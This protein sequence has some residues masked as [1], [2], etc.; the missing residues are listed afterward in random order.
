[1]NVRQAL[2]NDPRNHISL[3]EYLEICE[4]NGFRKHK[5]KLQL[6]TYL[7]ELGIC[8]HYQ[9][10]PLLNKTV[11]LKTDWCTNAVYKVL[12]TNQVIENLGRFTRADLDEIWGLSDRIAVIYE[13]K[14]VAIKPAD[15][16]TESEI[17]LLMAGGKNE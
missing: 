9:D 16:T 13:G 14:I 5:D 15:E 4:R 17:G 10:D 7:H 12:D 11:I 3:S 6:S 8:L 1:M 2:E